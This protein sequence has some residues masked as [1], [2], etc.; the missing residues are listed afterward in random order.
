MTFYPGAES[1]VGGG[2]NPEQTR[3]HTAQ[4]AGSAVRVRV[5]RDV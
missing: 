4:G 1:S 3:G 2:A 5:Q